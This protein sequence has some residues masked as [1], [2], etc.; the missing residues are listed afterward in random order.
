MHL[1]SHGFPTSHSAHKTNETTSLLAQII[2]QS[3]YH[4]CMDI[5]SDASESARWILQFHRGECGVIAWNQHQN[6]AQALRGSPTKALTH[7]TTVTKSEP[8]G[9]K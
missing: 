8:H 7:T 3:C 1:C 2:F 9:Q 5:C 6:I 4:E